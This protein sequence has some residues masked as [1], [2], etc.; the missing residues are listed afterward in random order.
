VDNE[1]P[2]PALWAGKMLGGM[3]FGP[4]GTMGH[5][6]NAFLRETVVIQQHLEEAAI[7]FRTLGHPCRLQLLIALVEREVCD[8]TTLVAL[9]GC[10]QPYISQHLRLLRRLGLVTGDPQGQRVCYRLA[11]LQVKEILEA[12]GLLS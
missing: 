1:A 5:G 11:N 8:V 2:L 4:T 12:A 3:V 10:R 7:L 6:A 9:C